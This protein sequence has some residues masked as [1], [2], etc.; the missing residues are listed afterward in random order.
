[1][2]NAFSATRAQ[3]KAPFV[4]AGSWRGSPARMIARS[5]SAEKGGRF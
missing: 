4:L 2:E 5:G 3:V 1:M